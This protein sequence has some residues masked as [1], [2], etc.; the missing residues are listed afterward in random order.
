MKVEFNH[1][2]LFVFFILAVIVGGLFTFLNFPRERVV[3]KDVFVNRSSCAVFSVDNV[4]SLLDKSQ[5]NE[6]F[7]GFFRRDEFFCV[8]TFNRSLDLVARDTFHELAHLYN[9][10]DREHFVTDFGGVLN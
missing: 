10:R 2:Q 9:F 7:N 8:I 3:F 5:V 4:S 6:S 1:T